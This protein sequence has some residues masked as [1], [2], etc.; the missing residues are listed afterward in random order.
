MNIA[1]TIV[2]CRKAKNLTQEALGEIV[3]VSNQSVS[4]WENGATAP[5]I[6]LIP[7][8]ADAL[9]ISLEEFFG[10]QSAN[11]PASITFDNFPNEAFG[12]LYQSFSEL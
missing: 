9:G 5:D 6:A 4:K 1:N 10:V 8:L 2:R 12:R 11:H 7:A 3:G